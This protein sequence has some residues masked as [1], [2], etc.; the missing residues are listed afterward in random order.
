MANMNL[1]A[2]ISSMSPWG[3]LDDCELIQNDDE[4]ADVEP[5]WKGFADR[6]EW[7]EKDAVDKFFYNLHRM[8]TLKYVFSPGMKTMQYYMALGEMERGFTKN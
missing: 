8:I 5:I 1:H 3:T 6:D 4:D 7:T 2:L